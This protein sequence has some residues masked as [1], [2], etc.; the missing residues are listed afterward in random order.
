MA[1]QGFGLKNNLGRLINKK[2]PKKPKNK[3]AVYFDDIPR[4]IKLPAKIYDLRSSSKTARYEKYK[5]AD[6]K[7]TSR[8]SGDAIVKPMVVAG[9]HKKIA[10]AASAVLS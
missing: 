5:A 7:T 10:R 8:A 6:Q 2:R 9:E 4:P 1:N 3:I